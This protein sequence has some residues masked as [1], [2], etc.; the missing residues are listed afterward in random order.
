MNSKFVALKKAQFLFLVSLVLMLIFP[1][2]SSAADSEMKNWNYLALGD[3]LAHGLQYD[4]NDGL[5]YADYIADHLSNLDKLD[6][7]SKDFTSS[8]LTTTEMLAKLQS[9]PDMQQAI[10]KAD[11]ITLSVGAND[12]LEILKEDPNGLN[13]PISATRI[14]T[15]AGN[16]YVQIMSGIRKLNPDATIFLMGYYNSFYAYPKEQQDAVSYVMTELNKGIEKIAIAS[17]SGFVP[18]YDAIAANYQVN[19]PNPFDVHPSQAGYQVIANEFW[20]QIK[21]TI[22]IEVD[23]IAGKNRYE[24]AVAISKA[25]FEEADTVVISRGDDFP[26]AL[27]G[28]PLAYKMNAPILLTGRT[29]SIEVKEEIQ[30]LKARNAI[31][32]GGNGAVSEYV[33]NEL[34]GMGLKTKRVGGKNRFETA[35]HIAAYLDGNPK[36]A[37]VANGMN[38]P[39]ALSIASFA[40]KEGYPILLTQQ[41]KLPDITNN[42]LLDFE[43]SIVVGGKGVV[44][45]DVAGQLPQPMRYSGPNRYA[46]SAEIATKL[47]PGDKAVIATGADFADALTGSILAARSESTFLLIPPTKF[48]ESIQKAAIELGIRK[49]TILGGEGAVNNNVKQSLE[50][51]K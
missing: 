24:T 8:G 42:A 44:S 46:T 49:F 5:S 25:S 37:I 16:N 32:L 13:D 4:G 21:M 45:E 15:N 31:I 20:K 23:R 50:K 39:D 28:S 41:N 1:S 14:L 19:L 35:A 22:P 3:S 2:L 30:R 43:E 26:D 11:L 29:L 34:K 36:K 40:A 27:S 9:N 6:Q 18:T 47:N 33:E 48:D 38:F 17:G 51:L 7:F 12:F 10:A